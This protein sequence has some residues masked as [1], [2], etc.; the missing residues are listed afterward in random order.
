MTRFFLA[1]VGITYLGLGLWCAALPEKAATSVG[2]QLQPGQGQSEFLTV[3]G[4]LE[5]GLGLVF[6]WPLYRREEVALPLLA[7][8]LIHAGLVLFRTLSFFLYTGFETTTYLLAVTEWV[9]FLGAAG[10][11]F[12]KR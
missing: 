7:C 5:V 4:G 2:F 10:L 11:L 6:L 1:A 12:L 9:I 8:F 3:Y